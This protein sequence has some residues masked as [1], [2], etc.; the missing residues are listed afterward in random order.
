M[1]SH[2]T[3]IRVHHAPASQHRDRRQSLMTDTYPCAAS[4]GL[5]AFRMGPIGALLSDSLE[6]DER[7]NLGCYFLKC[8]IQAGIQRF[9]S[10]STAG[11]LAAISNRVRNSAPLEPNLVEKGLLHLFGKPR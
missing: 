1:R 4:P 7:R 10:K 2:C 5:Y 6:Q 11:Q 9:I 3:V 8:I